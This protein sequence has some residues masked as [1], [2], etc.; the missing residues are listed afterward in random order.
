MKV[1]IV[2]GGICGLYLGWKLAERKEK[3][4]LFEKE[5]KVG[6]KACSSLFSERI[7]NFLPFAQNFIENEIDYCLLHFQKKDVFLRFSEKFFA[8]DRFLLQNQLLK[9]AKDAEAEIVLG[10]RV[11]ESFLEKILKDFDRVIGADGA[12]STVRKFLKLKK[13]NFLLGIQGFVKKRDFSN[14]AEVWP[15]QN[16][17]FWKI[18]RGEKVEYG[19]VEV[20][21]RSKRIF[22]ELK[23]KE[24]LKF[25]TIKSAPLAQGLV[26]PF[27]PKV[28]LCGE[29]SAL[30]KPW[31]YGGVIWGLTQ[32]NF[33]LESFPDF[34]SFSKKT[35]R[36][37]SYK[38]CASKLL[39]KLV[40]SIAPKAEFL[41]PSL[42]KIDGDFLF[43]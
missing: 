29:A 23:E 11:D 36:F 31:S 30:T 24:N 5:E 8:F 21:E 33:L 2:G 1:A 6:E 10:K 3:V 18:P 38:V 39:K 41:L 7:F 32:A 17:F 43:F 15:T 25:E 22:Q 14:L 4:V 35:K 37:F 12:D 40:F 20:G 13:P 19:I 34:I 16:G 27:D 26:L 28:T 42:I 9:I